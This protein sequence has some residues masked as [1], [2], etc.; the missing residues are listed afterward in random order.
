MDAKQVILN[1]CAAGVVP[2]ISAKLVKAVMDTGFTLDSDPRCEDIDS[3]GVQGLISYADRMN[4]A[5]KYRVEIEEECDDFLA[6]HKCKALDDVAKEYCQAAV[7][8]AARQYSD[9]KEVLDDCDP[10][11][12]QALAKAIEGDMIPLTSYTMSYLGA[13]RLYCIREYGEVWLRDILRGLLDDPSD[14]YIV[15]DGVL[16]V[17]D[18]NRELGVILPN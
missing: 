1:A 6:I 16:F 4:F 13:V 18:Q 11:L 12:L 7:S 14:F 10:R 3:G 15:P 5:M 9:L 8:H 17:Y 2:G